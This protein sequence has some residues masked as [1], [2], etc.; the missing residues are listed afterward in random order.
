MTRI[1]PVIASA[2]L[3][4]LASCAV[5]PAHRFDAF[6]RAAAG[7]ESDRGWSY[8]GETTR[9]RSYGDDLPAFVSDAKAAD[10][11]GF[12]WSEPTVVWEDDGFA[13]VEVMLLSDVD[14]VPDFLVARGLVGG[15]C[16][17]GGMRPIGL[18]TFV[19]SR[20]F[21]TGRLGAGARTGSQM[22]CN[23]HFIGEAAF[24]D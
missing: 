5:S 11:S 4:V 10:W 24:E 15:R 6:L 7:G 1:P 22:M 3:L 2:V 9:E 16:G 8:I 19:D 12:E 14:T 17:D 23:S 20:V 21:G 18:G 13:A